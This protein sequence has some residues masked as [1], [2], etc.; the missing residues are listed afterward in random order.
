MFFFNLYCYTKS[1]GLQL[2]IVEI[3]NSTKSST[4]VFSTK[5]FYLR[6]FFLN[7]HIHKLGQSYIKIKTNRNEDELFETIENQRCI[8]IHC[9][10][11]V[12]GAS[13]SFLE[14]GMKQ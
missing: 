2:Y 5:N 9:Y 11:K 10:L 1:K 12:Q 7:L 14:A 3:S 6:I 13:R 4:P 8:T